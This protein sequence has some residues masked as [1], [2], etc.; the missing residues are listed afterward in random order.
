[1]HK[2]TVTLETD[3]WLRLRNL[4]ARTGK[5]VGR[6]INEMLA[7]ALKPKGRLRFLETGESADVDDLGT[8]AEEYLREGLA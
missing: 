8:N 7:K 4:S 1:M 3:V 6:L 5:P 2:T